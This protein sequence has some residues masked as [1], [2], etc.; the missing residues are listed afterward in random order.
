VKRLVQ[1]DWTI[2][3][4]LLGLALFFGH[5]GAADFCVDT[6]DDPYNFRPNVLLVDLDVFP[7]VQ[8]RVELDDLHRWPPPGTLGSYT[9]LPI[10]RVLRT[11]ARR[12]WMRCHATST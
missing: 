9:G 12:A 5:L 3:Q 7:P 6:F 11:P 8:V 10:G 4:T 1:G 2:E